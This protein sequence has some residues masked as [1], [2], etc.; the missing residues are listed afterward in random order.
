MEIA[1]PPPPVL[2]FPFGLHICSI[3]LALALAQVERIAFSRRGNRTV[4]SS[5]SSSLFL[6]WWVVIVIITCAR[7]GWSKEQVDSRVTRGLVLYTRL[8]TLV[9]AYAQS[10][11]ALHIHTAAAYRC[12]TLPFRGSRRTGVH[13]LRA[14][15]PLGPSAM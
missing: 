15:I 7:N 4:L 5:L 8:D 10:R 6:S 11:R 14:E 12:S 9:L 3:S 13:N 1:I 2:I